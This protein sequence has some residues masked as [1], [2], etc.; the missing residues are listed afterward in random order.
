MVFQLMPCIVWVLSTT[1]RRELSLI[2]RKNI[3]AGY[4]E[5][6]IEWSMKWRTEAE[7]TWIVMLK[8]FCLDLI[9]RSRSRSLEKLLFLQI[10]YVKKS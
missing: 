9:S 5:A 6:I 4:T 8:T 3:L 1:R 10:F 7:N 2:G